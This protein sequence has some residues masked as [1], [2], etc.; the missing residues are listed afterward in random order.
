MGPISQSTI[1]TS[2]VLGVRLLIQAGTLLLVAR[3]LGPDDFGLFAGIAALAVLMGTF[4]TFGT[5]LVLLEVVSKDHAQCTH[6]LRYAIPTTLIVG[7]LLFFLYVFTCLQFF[8]S[9]GAS[10]TVIICIGLT[11]II[12][13]PLFLLSTTEDL[14]LEKTAQSQLLTIFPLGLRTLAVVIVLLVNHAEPLILFAWLYFISA[15]VS[16][17][18]RK[19][20]KPNAWLKA[21]QWR[22]ANKQELK[23]SAGYAALALT[24][25]GPSELDKI[26]AVKLL[27]LGLSGVYVAATRVIGAAALPVMALL[28]SAL[29]RLFRSH[30]G[31]GVQSSRLNRWIIAT[32]FIY[33]LFVASL[34]WFLAPWVEWLFGAKYQ[35]MTEILQWS[36]LVMPA[37]LLRVTLVNILMT[38]NKPWLRA[39]VE[40]LGMLILIVGAV[41]LYAHL[42]VYGII[43]ALAL[44]EIGM[45]VASLFIIFFRYSEGNL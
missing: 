24:A 31:E 36:C 43:L 27:P 12:L 33:S 35:D 13:L 41:L 7:S 5:H 18:C 38:M 30:A 11:E 34:L 22:L 1:R 19:I 39:G 17:G 4:S 29:P 26:L 40:S 21:R 20:Y 8:H 23:N 45:G 44:S 3:L 9:L 15:L 6:V 25:A 10:L 14:A 37:L 28:L 16:L 42:G 2:F 32:A